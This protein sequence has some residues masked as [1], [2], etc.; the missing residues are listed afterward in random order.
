MRVA[1]ITR[2]ADCPQLEKYVDINSQV[3]MGRMTQKNAP[4]RCFCRRTGVG[5]GSLEAAELHGCTFAFLD[6]KEVVL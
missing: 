2:C 4:V 5:F 1:A 3:I 6:L